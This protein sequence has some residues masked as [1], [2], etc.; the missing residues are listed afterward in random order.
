MTDR[1]SYILM[2]SS[3]KITSEYSG[4]LLLR[5]PLPTECIENA[6]LKNPHIEQAQVQIHVVN[7]QVG[8]YLTGQW[9][10]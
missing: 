9:R 1:N 5:K 6:A 8:P 4:E 7:E 2:L 10:R 3:S